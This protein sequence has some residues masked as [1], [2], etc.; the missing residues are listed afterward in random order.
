M[1]SY[2]QRYTYTVQIIWVSLSELLQLQLYT[3]WLIRNTS[4]WLLV[5]SP[6]RIRSNG[7]I[8][9]EHS[10]INSSSGSNPIKF[11]SMSATLH[12]CWLIQVFCSLLM[13]LS[14]CKRRILQQYCMH[15]KKMT[16]SRQDYLLF[17]CVWPGSS[18][19]ATSLLLHP[20]VS[21]SGRE[22]RSEWSRSGGR[23]RD[24]SGS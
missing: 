4:K 10:Q 15:R 20:G 23:N 9:W 19:A 12:S 1:R 22:E 14:I 8:L 24:D 6:C 13:V 18:C 5:Q 2:T 21:S 16:L 3:C 11:G 7:G 17:G